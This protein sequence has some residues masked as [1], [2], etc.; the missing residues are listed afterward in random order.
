MSSY[1]TNNPPGSSSLLDLWD[2]TVAFDNALNEDADTWV[3]RLGEERPTVPALTKQ[4]AVSA[5]KA[6]ASEAAASATLASALKNSITFE[7]GG[8]LNSQLDR[9]SD[10][11][12]LYYW[13]GQY[14]V[15][16]PA[17]A[18]VESSGG[19]GE[20]AW[21]PDTELLLRNLMK[22][23]EGGANTGIPQGGTVADA[24]AR[25]VTL[26]ALGFSLDGT[27][28]TDKLIETISLLEA[29][30]DKFIIDGKGDTVTVSRTIYIDL[31]K[32]GLRNIIFDC[33]NPVLTD[34]EPFYILAPYGSSVEPALTESKNSRV[35]FR[36]ITVVGPGVRNTGK[37]HGILHN[38]E[39]TFDLSNVRFVDLTI[40]K[41]DVGMVLG[42]NTYLHT[43]QNL[44]IYNCNVCIADT[45]WTGTEE[46]I[47]NAG[48]NIR[49]VDSTFAN[50]NSVFAM[51]GVECYLTFKNVSFDYTGGSPDVSK[52]QWVLS[53]QGITLNFYNCHFESG[54]QYDGVTASYFY[55][56][57]P[58]RVNIKGGV[59]QFGNTTYNNMPYLFYDGVGE[60]DFSLEDTYVY[61]RGFKEFAN[62]SLRKCLPE[63]N[64]GTSGVTPLIQKKGL[65]L[66]D[67]DFEKSVV[68]DNWHVSGTQ[69]SRLESDQLKA[70]LTTT[71]DGDGNIIPALKLARKPGSVSCLAYLFVR[72]PRNKFRGYCVVNLKAENAVSLTNPIAIQVGMIK[73]NGVSGSYGRPSQDVILNTHLSSAQ[74]LTVVPVEY[75]AGG[76][77]DFD[78]TYMTYDYLRIA[79]N[80][81]GLSTDN[82]LYI[83]GVRLDSPF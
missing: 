35:V 14:P 27:D 38:P 18:T 36:S 54:N 58:V 73:S 83:T 3:N 56:D 15:D 5:D 21:A 7:D 61:G 46:S 19:I 17:G 26:R 41:C 24:L 57:K 70:E 1:G 20:G 23:P 81:T 47:S 48:E 78:P 29:E 11:T 44:N 71:T 59:M 52:N 10:G 16:V 30:D 66:L 28:E 75:A 67:P 6:A 55:A 68:A 51:K 82:A 9:I 25:V 74:E 33:P 69:T 42:S 43:Y 79:V 53:K 45:V 77:L 50:S 49:F 4:A 65:F 32:V 34:G 2:N 40:R 62:S 13:T 8:R 37:V 31:V 60:A 39:K 64:H 63:V 72:K 76:T 12:F 22:S 80:I